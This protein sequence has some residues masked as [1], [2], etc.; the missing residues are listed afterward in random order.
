MYIS[1]ICVY[2]S[3]LCNAVYMDIVYIYTCNIYL[4][5]YYIYIYINHVVL[6]LSR[7]RLL[8]GSPNTDILKELGTGSGIP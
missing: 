6:N 4:Y 7:F 8:S 5:L 1:N 2:D 3:V